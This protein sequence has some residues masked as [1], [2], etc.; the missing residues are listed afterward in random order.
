MIR[1][2]PRSTLFPYTTLFRSTESMGMIGG[3]R[4]QNL[5]G[6]SR[7]QPNFNPNR[8]PKADNRMRNFSPEERQKLQQAER[9][10]GQPP[11]QQKPGK[12]E[13]AR[14]LG[15]LHAGQAD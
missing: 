8:P 1:R 10:F 15:K 14:L 9:R 4:P 11:P 13:R 2:P 5:A 12:P 7:R 3:D 6:E